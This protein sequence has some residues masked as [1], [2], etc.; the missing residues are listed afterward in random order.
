MLKS[1]IA[2]LLLISLAATAPKPAVVIIAGVGTDSLTIGK[3][4]ITEVFARYGK[5]DDFN[6]GVMQGTDFVLNINRYYYRK[7]DLIFMTNMFAPQGED[8]V[9][10]VLSDIIFGAKSGAHTLEGITI[11]K[12]SLE[13]VRAIYGEPDKVQES[14]SDRTF[15][16]TKKGISFT[17]N[18]DQGEIYEIEVFRSGLIGSHY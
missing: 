6:V 18:V 12:D 13:Q 3:T 5:R 10:A 2:F 8:T 15:I 9:H 14:G 11:G 7:Q 4:K 17:E 16:Y 1:L